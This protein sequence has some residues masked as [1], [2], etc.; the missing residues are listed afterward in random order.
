MDAATAGLRLLLRQAPV[1]P[2]GPR[3][4]GRR[5]QASRRRA[6]LPAAADPL[7]REPRRAAR[8]HRVRRWTGPRGRR[9]HCHP[10][11]R[12]ALARRPVRGPARAAAG[13]PRPAPRRAGRRRPARVLPPAGHRRGRA[14]ARRVD[15]AGAPR[16]A[17]QPDAPRPARVGLARRRAAPRRRGEPGRP[18]VP[19]PAS[20]CRGPRCAVR[21]WRL[22]DLLDGNAYDSDG[23]ELV[24]AG[25]YVDLPPWGAHVFTVAP[26]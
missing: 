10:A 9:R 26:G 12:D 11:R 17:G 18:P 13:V 2:A 3:G 21:R 25:L 19:G 8:G 1:R 7:H 5:P 15:A 16:L 23:D 4:R 24:D 20:R 14:A 6:G 22:T